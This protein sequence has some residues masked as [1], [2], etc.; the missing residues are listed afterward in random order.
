MSVEDPEPPATTDRAKGVLRDA[1]FLAARQATPTYSRASTTV[2]VGAETQNDGIAPSVPSSRKEISSTFSLAYR[3]SCPTCD[4]AHDG[5]PATARITVY[6]KRYVVSALLNQEEAVD[7]PAAVANDSDSS[8]GPVANPNHWPIGPMTLQI[9]D[10]RFEFADEDG[11]TWHA[12][13]DWNEDG[14]DAEHWQVTIIAS[15][16]QWVDR[17]VGNRGLLLA[18][19]EIKVVVEG[20]ELTCRLEGRPTYNHFGP[21]D[22]QEVYVCRGGPNGFDWFVGVQVF[23]ESE[24]RAW[25]RYHE[26]VDSSLETMRRALYALEGQRP[27][28]AVAILSEPVVEAMEKALIERKYGYV[29]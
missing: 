24:R 11:N 20:H 27:D 1:F 26:M 21:E 8:S 18:L 23:G 12:P 2:S 5:R 29:T 28:E 17:S 16:F 13:T 22:D 7:T 3:R 14:N 9:G 10:R 25:R 6:L 19:R 15:R 4:V